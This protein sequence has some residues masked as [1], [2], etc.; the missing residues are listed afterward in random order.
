[1]DECVTLEAGPIKLDTPEPCRSVVGV[2]DDIAV[3]SLSDGSTLSVAWPTPPET[4]RQGGV[5]VRAA[6][7]PSA[8][9]G[10]HRALVAGLSSD[11]RYVRVNPLGQQ[12]DRLMGPWRVGAAMFTAFGVLALLVASLGLY[13]VLA[14]GVARRKRELGIRAALGARRQDLIRMIMRQAFRLVI[15]GLVAGAAVVVVAGRI[16]D[17]V[18]FGVT[19]KDPMVF[20]LVAA[21]LLGAGLF[22]ALVPAWNATTIDPAATMQAD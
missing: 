5:V 10:P 8:L 21:T 18:L 9:V 19:A 2:Y 22:A 1:M 14:F 20:G 13:S 15:G 17:S 11:V 7:D 4:N 3:R 12:V 16:L 6:G